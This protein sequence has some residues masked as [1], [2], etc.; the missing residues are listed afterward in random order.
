MM[1]AGI[2]AFIIESVGIFGGSMFAGGMIAKSKGE[3]LHP[4]NKVAGVVGGAA[5]VVAFFIAIVYV[6]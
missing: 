4:V 5:L 6:R 2:I 1:D 3:P